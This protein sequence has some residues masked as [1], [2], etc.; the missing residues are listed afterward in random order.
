[1]EV[2]KHIG[3]N[4]SNCGMCVGDCPAARFSL[5]F[6]PRQIVIKVSR[7]L[8]EGLVSQ[9]S[10]IWKCTTCYT[11]QER[12]PSGVKPVDVIIDLRN[13]AF[14]AGCAKDQVPRIYEMVGSTG[15]SGVVTETIIRRREDLG[16]PPIS[17]LKT[18]AEDG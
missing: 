13:H 5:D 8:D 6:N 16:L 15:R 11:C 17:G 1:M 3:S 14:E 12:C 2:N 18:E 9:E 4:C 7:G 10:P